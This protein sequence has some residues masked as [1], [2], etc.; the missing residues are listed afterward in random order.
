MIDIIAIKTN[1]GFYATDN[2]ESKGY[3]NSKL[4]NLFVDGQVKFTPS[5]KK[6]WFFTPLS[7]T[8]LTMLVS[9]PPINERYELKDPDTFPNLKTVCLYE[10]VH[11]GYDD[12]SEQRSFTDEFK[13]V[14]SLYE[15]KQDTPEPKHEAVDFNWIVFAEIEEINEPG[16]FN[17]SFAGYPTILPK[18]FP[19]DE[20]LT[21]P[22]VIHEKP[23]FLTSKESYRIIR[24]YVQSNI[25][26][27]VAKITSDYDF[28]FTVKKRLPIKPYESKYETK[29]A[30]G[31]S[32]AK[33]RFSTTYHKERQVQCFEMTHNEASRGTS[34]HKGY[35]VI[36]GFRGESQED[37]KQTIDAYLLSLITEINL[38]LKDCECCG[39]TG[40]ELIKP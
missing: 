10:D 28:C 20:M 26:P 35:T 19:I 29:K 14:S 13:R 23:A 6:D 3:F 22:L 27:K 4:S 31:R 2:V 9:Q 37:L 32:Y 8:S 36:D 16:K 38:P 7:P 30:N 34:G 24:A 1:S 17:Y 5:W 21:P 25:N 12:D 11:L 15:F 33:P 18:N 40:I 39:G